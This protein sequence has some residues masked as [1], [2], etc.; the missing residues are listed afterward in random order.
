[1]SKSLRKRILVNGTRILDLL[2]LVITFAT[3]FYFNTPG[4]TP[5]SP[6]V[7][8]SM[9]I[10]LVNI[11][12]VL[13]LLIAWN[14]LFT[15][16]GL[17]ERRRL[18]RRFREWWDIIKATTIGVLFIASLAFL[19][20]EE[21]ITQRVL[22]TFW[23]A[24]IFFTILSRTLVRAYLV[25]LRNRGRNLRYI[26]FIGSGQRAVDWAKK[27]VERHDLGYRLVGFIDDAYAGSCVQQIPK[28][29]HLCT[30]KELPNFLESHVVDEVFIAL[31][32]KSYYEQIRQ[33]ADLCQE[34]GI[35]CRVPSNWFEF[36][37]ARTVAFE[38]AGEPV[39]TIYTG[40]RKQ[41]EHL[42]AKRTMDLLLAG[43]AL[44]F[45]MPL[46]AAIAILIK[47]ASPGPVFF[48]Q[49]RVGYNR[50]RFKII[51][52]RTMV[53]DAEK[54]QDE[55]A[56]FNESDGPT[57]KIQNDPRITRIG[58]WLRRTSLDEIP[59]LFNV[60][61]GEM[62]LV[63]PRPL[64]VRDVAGMDERWQKRR[65]SMRPG[66]TCLWQING[67]NRLRFY[68]WMRLDLQYID[69]WSMMLDVKILL[70]TFPV[71]I[72]ADGQ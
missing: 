54:M 2:V 12:A 56:A 70:K 47:A 69:Q 45:L 24:C 40:S 28:A 21:S 41:L 46:L 49:D 13:L 72:R 35:L 11:L 65:F 5:L 52:F 63:G 27:I 61:K 50:R 20:R 39:L 29:R 58:R 9:R 68:D 1:M 34:L 6:V 32:V 18:D 60:L 10:R 37:V 64:P 14:Q 55:L 30:L 22:F 16:F 33:I 53:V 67:R 42:W 15:F 8:F 66:L 26:V 19:L 57:F 71:F 25:R 7:F 43:V 17:Y 59:Q 51:K 62:S 38:L 4:K 36:K 31:P 23:P 44:F 3:V 48:K